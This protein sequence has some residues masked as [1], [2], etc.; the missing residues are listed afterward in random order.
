[1]RVRLR[2]AMWLLE[3]PVS[4]RTEEILPRKKID[5]WDRVA[6]YLIL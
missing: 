2:I 1:L 6:L 3:L 4:K 5:I